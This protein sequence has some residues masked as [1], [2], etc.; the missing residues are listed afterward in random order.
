M[1]KFQEMIKAIK[2]ILD[3]IDPFPGLMNIFMAFA[4]LLIRYMDNHQGIP[5]QYTELI[6]FVVIGAFITTVTLTIYKALLKHLEKSNPDNFLQVRERYLRWV[7]QNCST[8]RLVGIDQN[9]SNPNKGRMSLEKLYIGLDTYT[10][11]NREVTHGIL[12]GNQKPEYMSVIDGLTTCLANHM[13]LLGLPGTG[14][15]TFIRYLSLSMAKNILGKGNLPEEWKMKPL[16]P[17]MISLG[18]FADAIPVECKNGNAEMIEKFL[19]QSLNN[20]I[21]NDGDENIDFSNFVFSVL[22][23]DGA[24]MMFDGL[25]EV[26]NLE[27]RP[28]VVRAIEDFINKYCQYENIYS[29]VT[30]RTYSY[31]HDESWKLT[32]W[33]THEIALLDQ[34]KIE[35]FV[36]AWYTHLAEIEK[37]RMDEF[38][39]KR[40]KLLKTLQPGDRRRLIEVAAYP[41]ILTV[42]AVVHTHFGDLPDT[43]AQVY[44]KCIDLLL[45]NW[46]CERQINGKKKKLNILQAMDLSSK[47]E[48]YQAL[49][50]VAYEA[51]GMSKDSNTSQITE[52]L[53]DAKLN[54]YLD[55]NHEKVDLFLEYCQSANG[56]LMLYGTSSKPNQH[57][58][59]VYTFPHLTFEEYM[60]ARYL[61]NEP[62]DEYVYEKIG[63]TD[64]WDE[65]IR[66]LGEHLC[67]GSQDYPRMGALLDSLVNVPT[68]ASQEQKARMIWIAGEMLVLYRGAFPSRTANSDKRVTGLLHD[69]A[70]SSLS[71]PRIRTNCADLA[72]ELGYQPHDLYSFAMILNEQ[73]PEFMMAR[74]TVTNGQYERF[75][76]EKNFTN[77]QLWINFPTYS[78]PDRNNKI[79][80][81]AETGNK[82]WEWLQQAL[83]YQKDSQDGILYPEY[84]NDAAL[85]VRR[86]N[87]PVVGI[88]WWEANAYCRWLYENWEQQEEGKIYPKPLEVRLPNE[89]EWLLAASNNGK[90]AYPWGIL[91]NYE[92]II[93][94]AN[95]DESDIGKTTPVWMY[96]LGESQIYKIMDL[97]GNVWEWQANYVDDAPDYF[98]IRGGAWTY[99]HRHA[100]L[101]IRDYLHPGHRSRDVGFRVLCRISSPQ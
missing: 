7:I 32:G 11:V 78:E 47:N 29:M 79:N 15:S 38:E 41:I 23:Q 71:S 3:L 97:S 68:H 67:F 22:E 58:R 93:F 54:I 2:S 43:R 85:G 46:H 70:I 13:V 10:P 39:D 20:N 63:Q 25:D 69:M 92:N 50:E 53:L 90:G 100:R 35:Y 30:C 45:I 72:D 37:S 96:K 48:L 1:K 73:T 19:I 26:A 98:S 66:L 99:S 49:W 84:W 83:K 64:R 95:T 52:E 51:H 12:M 88:S 59:K 18:L 8:L 86:K 33:E 31:M 91:E 55:S 9:A 5:Q 76:D 82:G 80:R 87:T 21:V 57:P 14:K 24:L 74:Y 94:Y 75:L 42:M 62:P 28:I 65:V 61:V 4:L 16:I 89:S 56:L 34:E 40:D 101:A 27:Q 6:Y 77:P 36:C 60:A 44:E 17:F 81:L